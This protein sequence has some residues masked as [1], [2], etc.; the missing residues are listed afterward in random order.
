[1]N[2][3]NG[4]VVVLPLP[5]GNISQGDRELMCRDYWGIQSGEATGRGKFN[6]R[7]WGHLNQ[8]HRRFV[9]RSASF[10]NRSGD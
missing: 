6:A 8:S 5:D 10:N 7:Q 3:G 1:M 9:M 2:F 4:L